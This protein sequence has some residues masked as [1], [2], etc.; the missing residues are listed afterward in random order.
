[1]VAGV[2]QVAPEF[3]E[4]NAYMGKYVADGANPLLNYM[5]FLGLGVFLGGYI[6]AFTG[7]RVQLKLEKGPNATTKSRI[8][9]ALGGG[10][11]MG[12]AARLAYGCTSGQALS[13]GASLAAGSWAFMMA[14]FAGGYALAYFVRR[15]WI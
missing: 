4:N 9:S 12:F 8:I 3:V 14:V 1:M 7:R 13:G 6:G 10:I 2:S 11:I 15:Q 5:V